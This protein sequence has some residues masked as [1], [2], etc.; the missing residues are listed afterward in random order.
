MKRYAGIL[1]ITI[2]TVLVLALAGCGG[3]ASGTAGAGVAGSTVQSRVITTSGDAQVKVV[4][5][6]VIVTLG[7]G[8]QGAQLDVAKS[9]NDDIVRRVLERVQGFGV[10]PNHIQTE[11]VG[12]NPVYDYSSGS[13]PRL[14][15][16]N[17]QKTIVV[18]L[19]DLTKF[20]DLLSGALAAG[21]NYVHNVEF[22]TTELRKHRDQAR[23]LAVQAAREK[24]A[25]LAGDLG[26]QLGE[27]LTITEEQNTWRS[28]YGY[29]WASRAGQS[30]SQNVVVESGSSTLGDDAT[31]APGQ[32]TVD[33]RVSVSFEIR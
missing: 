11:Y 31:V 24:A 33:A 23:A 20:E 2:S 15:G 17:V 3:S 6:E 22:R 10:P 26:K 7:V 28:W 32:I 16:Y 14:T 1:G 4:P 30:M 13:L 25:A 19:S 27:P 9:Q 29:G 12:I 21:A 5:D 8:T 18:T